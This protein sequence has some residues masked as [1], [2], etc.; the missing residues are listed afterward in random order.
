MSTTSTAVAARIRLAELLGIGDD[1]PMP[2]LAELIEQLAARISAVSDLDVDPGARFELAQVLDLPAGRVPGWHELVRQ[3]AHQREQLGRAHGDLLAMV[4]EHAAAPSPEV[5]AGQVVLDD[6]ATL[7]R[8]IL[9][10][11]VERG[12][13]AADRLGRLRAHLRAALPEMDAQVSDAELV[14][15][16]SELV[17]G[18]NASVKSARVLASLLGVDIDRGDGWSRIVDA[19]QALTALTPSRAWSALVEDLGV[20]PGPG[21]TTWRAVVERVRE[22]TNPRELAMPDEPGPEVEQVWTHD[23]YTGD[24]ITWL[25]DLD[26]GRPQGWI[27]EVG[28][29]HL[30]WSEL[31]AH[32][33][34]LLDDPRPALAVAH[35]GA[36]GVDDS[37]SEDDDTAVVDDGYRD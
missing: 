22:L 21:V 24:P 13:D 33:P 2:P 12:R 1:Q 20:T 32:G 14:T 8:E 28:G 23:A 16:V 27:R 29:G 15:S 35:A 11:Q 10:H 34:V 19:V 31:L 25:R 7:V 3:V 4:R 9:G 17:A 18:I 5:L 30:F 26:N 36:G 6:L 37:W